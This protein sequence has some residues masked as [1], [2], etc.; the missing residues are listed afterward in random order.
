MQS[1]SMAW[2]FTGRG[3]IYISYQ[4][5]VPEA[6]TYEF[7]FTR[8]GEDPHVSTVQGLPVVTITNPEQ[9]VEISRQSEFDITWEDNGDGDWIALGW[10]GACVSGFLDEVADNGS[11]TVNAG[12]LELPSKQEEGEAEG[13]ATEGE[14]EGDTEGETEGE[15]E[16]DGENDCQVF[17]ELRR[18][19]QGDLAETLKGRIRAFSVDTVAFWAVP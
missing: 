5:T 12:A 4:A 2:R 10:S 15:T 18:T 1:P 16:G 3:G 14:T 7:V 17:L 19:Q 6:E 9:G 8:E 13:E 11:Y